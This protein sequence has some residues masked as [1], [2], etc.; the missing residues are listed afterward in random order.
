MHAYMH[1]EIGSTM[2][3]VPERRLPRRPHARWFITTG[4][5][6]PIQEGIINLIAVIVPTAENSD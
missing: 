4:A 3:S 2:C 6:D 5:G 1:P